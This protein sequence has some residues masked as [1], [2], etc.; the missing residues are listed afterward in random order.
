MNT[1]EKIEEL[2][3]VIL[4]YEDIYNSAIMA[5]DNIDRHEYNDIEL[6]EGSIKFMYKA[7]QSAQIFIKPSEIEPIS[8]AVLEI[9]MRIDQ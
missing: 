3:K 5:K 7:A 8:K 6:M 2:R 9:I 1:S 4:N